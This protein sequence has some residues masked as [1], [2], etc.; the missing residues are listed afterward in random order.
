MVL[1]LQSLICIFWANKELMRISMILFYYYSDNPCPRTRRGGVIRE[2]SIQKTRYI[3]SPT[4]PPLRAY[5]TGKE[6]CVRSTTDHYY[7]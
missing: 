4:D 2:M 7:P 3:S 6:S 1:F 5:R